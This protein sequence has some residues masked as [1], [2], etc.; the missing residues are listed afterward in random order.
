MKLYTYW[1]SSAA[2]R[3]RIALHLKGVDHEQVPIHLARGEHRGDYRE[4]NP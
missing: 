3:V 1:R 4:R 2:Y